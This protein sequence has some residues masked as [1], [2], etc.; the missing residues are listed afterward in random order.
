MK[1]QEYPIPKDLSNCAGMF[2]LAKPD[3]G[4]FGGQGVRLCC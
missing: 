2:H 3:I 4:G 1:G